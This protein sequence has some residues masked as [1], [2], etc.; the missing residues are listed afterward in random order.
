MG[1][2]NISLQFEKTIL[3]LNFLRQQFTINQ[4]PRNHNDQSVL[5]RVWKRRRS[6]KQGKWQFMF[7]QDAQYWSW[8]QYV[9]FISFRWS[10]ILL[11]PSMYGIWEAG[12]WGWSMS[13]QNIYPVHDALHLLTAP[14][15]ITQMLQFDHD[16]RKSFVRKFYR[17]L[18][19]QTKHVRTSV[20]WIILHFWGYQIKNIVLNFEWR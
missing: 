7:I 18:N 15:S 5:S 17:K 19:S 4:K 2:F 8:E 16:E 1:S 6:P 10:V 9:Y 13:G 20:L 12:T 3:N 11:R 14:H